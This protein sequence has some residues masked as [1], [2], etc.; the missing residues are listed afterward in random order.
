MSMSAYLQRV[1]RNILPRSVAQT[2]PEAFEEWHFTGNMTDHEDTDHNCEL[3]DQDGLRYHFEIENSKTQCGLMIGSSCILKFGI[4]VFDDD[5]LRL[6]AT[7]ARKHL[8]RLIQDMRH[9]ACLK[10][11]AAVA[12]HESNDI[13]KGALAYLEREGSLTPKLAW[14]VLW[15]LK[16]WGIDHSPEYFKIALRT[17]RCRRDLKLMEPDRVHALWPALS[18]SQRKLAV[19]WGHTAPIRKVMVGQAATHGWTYEAMI[20]A[21]WTD[22][23]LVAHGMM[24]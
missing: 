24:L 15:K 19:S 17:D 14:V 13:L 5:G 10:A 18:P 4:A 8:D 3:C 11:L 1:A 16:Q 22:A 6:T 20:A 12:A 9:A 21:G 7:E 23:L 2:L